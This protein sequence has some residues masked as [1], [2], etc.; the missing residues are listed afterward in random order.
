MRNLTKL[1]GFNDLIHQESSILLDALA[2]TK[3]T[4]KLWVYIYF[5][6]MNLLL[7]RRTD[8]QE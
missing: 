4:S 7:S 3:I 2:I 1:L 8:E 6:S 5:C